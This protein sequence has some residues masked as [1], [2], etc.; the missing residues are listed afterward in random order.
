MNKLIAYTTIPCDA[1]DIMERCV[2]TE[3]KDEICVAA[4]AKS[5]AHI[6]RQLSNTKVIVRCLYCEKEFETY[7]CKIKA[8]RGRYCSIRCRNVAHGIMEALKKTNPFFAEGINAGKNNSNWKGGTFLDCEICGKPFWKYPSRKT[9]TCSHACGCERGRL[10][11]LGILTT[12]GHRN[13]YNGIKGWKY[14][15]VATLERDDFICQRCKTSYKE[16]PQFLHAHHKVYL[17]NGGKNN[18]SNLITLCKNCH[19]ELHTLAG[20]LRKR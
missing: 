20:D 17:S 18:V 12:L 8:G 11:K 2:E 13:Q 10:V 5:I 19:F 9:A 16:Q 6:I 3:S 14:L 7:Y 1:P 4:T 15:R